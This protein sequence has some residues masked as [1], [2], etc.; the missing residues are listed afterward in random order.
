MIRVPKNTLQKYI[1]FLIRHH[2][3]Q[4][5]FKI[6]PLLTVFTE[7]GGRKIKKAAPKG[8]YKFGALQS[9]EVEQLC[10]AIVFRPRCASFASS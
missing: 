6:I 2:L 5:I 8:G 9:G 3:C 4:K 7:K 1:K 10:Y